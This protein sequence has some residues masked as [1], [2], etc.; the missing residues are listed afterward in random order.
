MLQA[1]AEEFQ[2]LLD[3]PFRDAD[4][5]L[6]MAIHESGRALREG[7]VT[8]QDYNR[9]PYLNRGSSLTWH[10]YEN[11]NWMMGVYLAAQAHR[12]IAGDAGGVE[13]GRAMLGLLFDIY[14]NH[15]RKIETGLFGKPI[16]G[17]GGK[18]TYE[19]ASETNSDQLYGILAG[20]WDFHPLAHADE[21]RKI[22]LMIVEIADFFRRR[23][24]RMCV[25]GRSAEGPNHAVHASKPM[26]YQLMAHRFA[27]SMGFH[28]EYL[29]WFEMNRHDPTINATCLSYLHWMSACGK[30]R[31]DEEVYWAGIWT[32]FIDVIA[33]LS[34][35]DPDRRELFRTRLRDWWEE[36]EPMLMD[37]GSVC[38]SMMVTPETRK[39][40]PIRPGEIERG[41]YSCFWGAPVYFSGQWA[42][43]IAVNLLENCPGMTDRVRPWL[44]KL[45][46]KCDREGLRAIRLMSGYELPKNLTAMS[47]QLGAPVLW[48]YAYWRARANGLLSKME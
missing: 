5:L 19:V 15:T 28:E 12:A 42:A 48:L 14:F 10:R 26:L 30:T 22:E 23:N 35:L 40:R 45:L 37:D 3:G 11:T 41:P 29:R 34:E 6:M 31:G 47:K 4:G 21:R 13:A 39:W 1:R 18:A 20:L 9:P 33:R 17:E 7:D 2:K 38:V 27:P 8:E 43:P 44:I 25:R 36:T 32:T 16:V 24:Y 46:G